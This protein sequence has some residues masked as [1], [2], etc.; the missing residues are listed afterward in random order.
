MNQIL[1][2]ASKPIK[3]RKILY[4]II[5]VI[6]SL[7]L[8]YYTFKFIYDKYC[9]NKLE[10][11]S[12]H[13]NQNLKLRSLYNSNMKDNIYIGT[14]TID[15]INIEYPVFNHFSYD[16]LKIAPCKLCGSINNNLCIIGHNYNDSR[17][18]G[19]IFELNNNDVIK[20]TD[21]NRKNLLI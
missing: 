20:F 16:N 2:N 14:L 19:K 18:F 11:Y 13:I 1:E 6:L 12:H 17:F 8:F 5:S 15:I 3:L 10:A 7:V 4:I 21:L 9:N